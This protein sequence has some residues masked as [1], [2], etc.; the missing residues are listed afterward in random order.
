VIPL[1]PGDILVLL[2]CAALVPASWQLVRPDPG[3][4]V[5]VEVTT[6]GT[7]PRRYPLERD[8]LIEVD[9]SLGRSV[10]EIRQRAVRFVDSPCSTRHCILSGWHRHSG[11]STACLPNRVGITLVAKRSRFDAINF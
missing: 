8:R 5:A 4:A 3:L 1:R 11:D 7:A 2:A 9:G 10:I 6:P